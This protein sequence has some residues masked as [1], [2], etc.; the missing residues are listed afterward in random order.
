MKKNIF[1]LIAFAI[2]NFSIFAGDVAV[3]NE[4]GFSKDGN[5]Y[6]FGVYGKTD[7]KFIPYAEIYGV[8]VAKNDFIPGKIYK[9]QDK[10]FKKSSKKVYEDL[11]AKNYSQLKKYELYAAK[12]KDVLYVMDEESKKSTDEIVFT[13]FEENNYLYKVQLV[14][15]FYG[16]KS[17]FY[18]HT[19]VYDKNTNELYRSFY[20]G[21]E[22][23]K[24]PNVTG[25]KI[26]KISTSEDR[27]S[28]VFVI[29]KTIEDENGVSIRYMVETKKLEKTIYQIN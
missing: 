23:I 14:P 11:Y 5:T 20:A 2:F 19:K 13:S 28:I 9:S 12:P 18:I 16:K 24:R 3:F 4:I 8:D 27:K 15:T 21:N 10:S 7:K 29:E 17:S 25:Y 6:F 22:S 26:I 1:V